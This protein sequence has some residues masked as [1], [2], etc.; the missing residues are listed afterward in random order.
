MKVLRTDVGP[1][2][3]ARKTPQGFL[4]LDGYASRVG[5]FEYTDS[6]YPGGKRR[7][8]RLPEDVF[9]AD[10][11][12]SFQGLPVTLGHPPEGEVSPGN[13]RERVVG[14]V[15]EPASRDGDKVR[16]GK[17]QVTHHDAVAAVESKKLTALSVGYFVELDPTPGNHP[18]HGRYDGIQRDLKINHLALV[19]R[20][21]AGEEARVRLDS[22]TSYEDDSSARGLHAAAE[23]LTLTGRTQMD[24]STKKQ[25]EEL[26]LALAREKARA[27]ALTQERDDARKRADA[28]SGA[29]DELPK[30]RDQVADARKRA[31]A[32]AGLEAQ[33]AELKAEVEAG[34]A[35]LAEAN[36]P[37]RRA[38]EVKERIHLET[39]ARAILGQ[40]ARLDDFTD[41]ELM[42]SCLDKLGRGVS[43]DVSP[44]YLRARFD[45]A[46]ENHA[47]QGEALKRAG[48]IIAG[49]QRRE[50]QRNDARSAREKFVESQQNAWTRKESAGKEA[51]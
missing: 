22:A 46:A 26:T 10:V 41:V 37:K 49:G 51:R 35:K 16:T 9:R 40:D 3:P 19:E 2:R 6:R 18:V 43:K 8:L 33:V 50:E 4:V 28:A 20:G 44:D 25:I 30:L 32:V 1:L 11:L 14:T 38:D 47:A 31:D 34:K 45:A 36:D 5:V 27:D 23:S 21:R 17:I 24:E 15:L 13:A 29:A 7:E 42:R 12:D 39:V 48:T